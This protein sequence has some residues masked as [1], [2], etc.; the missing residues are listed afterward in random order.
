MMYVARLLVMLFVLLVVQATWV[1][2]LSVAGVV[3]DLF[4]ALAFA[5]AARR[6]PI[7]GT[8]WGFGVGLL[9]DV[10]QPASIGM[11][12]LALS[13]TGFSVGR[14]GRALDRG[15]PIVQGVLLF[16]AALVADTLRMIWLSSSGSG[17]L[18]TLWFR[19]ALPGALY[20]VILIPLCS[21]AVSA[22]LGRKDWV[23]GA[24]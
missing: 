18:L 7:Q 15:N 1:P 11:N 8:W 12:A 5:V 16:L 23:L 14:V 2:R 22:L 24:S 10:E 3:P 13:L 6:G 20:T 4:V 17:S 19:Y 9:L 21:R